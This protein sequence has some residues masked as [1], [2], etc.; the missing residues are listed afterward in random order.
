MT[1]IKRVIKVGSFGQWYVGQ[2]SFGMKEEF[3]NP[4]EEN[5]I[6]RI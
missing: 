4:K 2:D 6:L 3:K 1:K 5:N